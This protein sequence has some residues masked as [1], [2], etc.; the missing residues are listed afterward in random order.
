VVGVSIGVKTLSLSLEPLCLLL[1]GAALPEY[2]R[3][4]CVTV[5]KSSSLVILTALYMNT[6]VFRKKI[7]TCTWGRGRRLE[8]PDL[9]FIFSRRGC[10]ALAFASRGATS[11]SFAARGAHAPLC[12]LN[13]LGSSRALGVVSRLAQDTEPS[14]LRRALPG[15][16]HFASSHTDSR[17]HKCSRI[18]YPTRDY[19]G[20]KPINAISRGGGSC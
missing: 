2:G 20:K 14:Q 5:K 13:F 15:A 8:A 9:R 7:N 19:S 1:R 17:L 6:A 16:E 18:L 11:K 4:A 12:L 3:S 10:G